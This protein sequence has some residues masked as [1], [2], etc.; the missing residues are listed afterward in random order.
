M[1]V[2]SVESRVEI[3]ILLAQAFCQPLSDG[4]RSE[5]K[6]FIHDTGGR[7]PEKGVRCREGSAIVPI[8]LIEDLFWQF[9]PSRLA[10]GIIQH[11]N[12][13]GPHVPD[14][15][16]DAQIRVRIVTNKQGE[17]VDEFG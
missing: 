15:V 14:V 6:A 10:A 7:T 12:G 17:R 3:D 8:P 5:A 2:S 16:N 4:G 11:G 13:K 1:S 9:T